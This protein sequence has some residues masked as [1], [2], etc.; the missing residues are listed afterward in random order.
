MRGRNTL[1]K[2]LIQGSLFPE[3]ST[4]PMSHT[5]RQDRLK[6][7]IAARYY[8]YASCCRMLY[9]DCIRELEEEFDRAERTIIENLES[10]RAF[11]QKL[12]DDETAPSELKKRYPW[13]DWGYRPR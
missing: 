6:N 1:H 10:R 2:N 9:A 13:F 7:K 12:V 3:L 8:Y 4:P 5:E 11:I